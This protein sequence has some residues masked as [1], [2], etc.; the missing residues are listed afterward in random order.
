MNAQTRERGPAGGPVTQAHSSHSVH[1]YGSKQ[2]ALIAEP[3][4][5]R[6]D[7][8]T[9]T[10]AATAQL[11]GAKNVEALILRTL[12]LRGPMT[13]HEL[14]LAIP[15]R[16]PPTLSTARARLTRRGLVVE[17]E[18][19]RP[20]VFGHPM[21]VWSLAPEGSSAPE[22]ERKPRAEIR[23]AR[24]SVDLKAARLLVEGRVSVIAR[25]SDEIRARVLGDTG[26]YDVAV[27]ERGRWWCACA[28][29]GPRCSHIAAVRLVAGIEGGR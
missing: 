26:V 18:A 2:L 9:A 7:I 27:D 14:A 29:L 13:D 8:D 12:T 1:Q 11:P 17:T 25:T 5:R 24:E 19:R 15:D 6:N 23:K 3:T 21:V 16:H 4:A 22:P 28:Y 20:S 10:T